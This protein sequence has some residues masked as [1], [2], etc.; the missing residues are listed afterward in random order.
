VF[1]GTIDAVVA[2]GAALNVAAVGV[3][4][5]KAG[6]GNARGNRNVA[7]YGYDKTYGAAVA[8]V[9]KYAQTPA[10]LVAAGFLA[11]NEASPT[12]VAPSSILVVFDPKVAVID[13]HVR[14]P[15]GVRAQCVIAVSPDPIGP[16]TYVE[17][18]GHGRVQRLAGY[19]PGTY[20]V[21]ACTVRAT[22]RSA[23]VGPISVIVK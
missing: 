12:L 18:P 23:W 17:L 22:A 4:T 5:G 6:L 16:A 19:A 8:Q 1:K 10:D 2:A 11:L 7:R 15:R 9:E 14:Y 13:I 20:W 3:D 21:R